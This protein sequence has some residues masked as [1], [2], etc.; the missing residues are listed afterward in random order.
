MARTKKPG[1]PGHRR[2]PCHR[3]A[4]PPA[5]EPPPSQGADRRRVR[6]GQRPAGQEPRPATATG[7]HGGGG[8][9]PGPGLHR[10]P[11]PRP[12]PATPRS[13][14]SGRTSTFVR[15]RATGLLTVPAEKHNDPCLAEAITNPVHPAGLQA[16]PVVHRP[17]PGPVHFRR[18]GVRQ[19]PRGPQRPQ[20]HLRRAPPAPGVHR[21]PEK[22]TARER[23]HPHRQAGGAQVPEDVRTCPR[24]PRAAR[25]AKGAK[26][27]VTHYRVLERLPGHTVVEVKLETGRRNQIRVQFAERGFP[28][29]GT[30]SRQSPAKP[31]G[32][33]P[34]TPSCWASATRWA[35]RR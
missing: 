5:G 9:R 16:L 3:G 35:A 2:R 32:A 27:A 17:P 11:P 22:G 19:D 28:C 20:A 29:W 12:V 13:R 7:R 21:H 23:R 30:K 33:R 8:I 25:D 6:H 14:S 1:G 24:A 26:L 15:G 10:A 4:C 34:C 18:P 31:S